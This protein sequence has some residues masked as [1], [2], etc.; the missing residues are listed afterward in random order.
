MRPLTMARIL[1]KRAQLRPHETWTR[2]E[3]VAHQSR[4]FD[5]LRAFALAHSPFYGNWHRGLERAP[6]ADLPVVTKATMMS[7]VDDIVTDRSIHLADLQQ[8][9]EG[10]RGDELFHGR[11]WVAATSGSSGMRSVIP[12]NAEGGQ[13]LR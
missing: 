12:S 8:H 11:Y 4:S 6:L 2:A 3:L 1:W 10:L 5:E 9:L 13:V 7:H